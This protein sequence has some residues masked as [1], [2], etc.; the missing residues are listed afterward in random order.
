MNNK[1][2]ITLL[3]SNSNFKSIFV[4]DFFTTRISIRIFIYEES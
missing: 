4:Y 3:S 1:I 2:I